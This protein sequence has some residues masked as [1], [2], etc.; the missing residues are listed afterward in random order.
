MTF[1]SARKNAPVHCLDSLR[2]RLGVLRAR[3][4]SGV[5]SKEFQAAWDVALG[6]TDLAE[7]DALLR[8][9]ENANGYFDVVT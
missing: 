3:G 8:R 1:V 6:R 2:A 4:V 9:Y 5:S 7:A